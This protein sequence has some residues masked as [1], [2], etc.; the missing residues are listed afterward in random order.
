ML[1]V[2]T[3]LDDEGNLAAKEHYIHVAHGDTYPIS[4]WEING[5][6][7]TIF[8]PDD[9]TSRIHGMA[10]NVEA[11]FCDFSDSNVVAGAVAEAAKKKGCGCKK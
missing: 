4:H 3:A 8:F 1:V 5:N 10:P 11:S 6:V 2:E 7:A 9:N